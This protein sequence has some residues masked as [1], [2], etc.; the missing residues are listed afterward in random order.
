MIP[1]YNQA[2]ALIGFAGRSVVVEKP[3]RTPKYINSPET[4]LFRK[5]E[6]L[7]AFHIAWQFIR[8]SKHAEG[9]V[10]MLSVTEMANRAL[11]LQWGRL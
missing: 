11:L 2:N 6:E 3:D 1:I 7:Y 9:R 10:L 4:K 8:A 5:G